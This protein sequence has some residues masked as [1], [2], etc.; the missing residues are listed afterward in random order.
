MKAKEKIIAEAKRLNEEAIKLMSDTDVLDRQGIK[1][2]FGLLDRQR[3]RQAS[4]YNAEAI[5]L[6]K[7]WT[8]IIEE[9]SE[10]KKSEKS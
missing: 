7:A 8:Y 6:I 5:G 4:Q 1:N 10:L 2:L 9:E 3:S